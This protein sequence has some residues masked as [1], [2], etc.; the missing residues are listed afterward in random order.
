MA[1]ISIIQLNDTTFQV[2]L[3][4]QSTTTHKVTLKANYR[5]KLNAGRMSS[6]DLIAFSF[7]FLLARE[8]N[9]SILRSFDLS[10]IAHYYSE[11]EREL[12]ASALRY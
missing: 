2:T 11:F 10:E 9:T 6:I 3:T 4:T 1:E 12:S 5:Q 7:K 8:S